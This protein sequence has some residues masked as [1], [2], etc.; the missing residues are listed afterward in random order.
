MGMPYRLISFKQD[1]S[2]TLVASREIVTRLVELDGGDDVGCARRQ[3]LHLGLERVNSEWKG[4][5][6]VKC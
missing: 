5:Y 4:V 1:H 3:S 2:T 6:E